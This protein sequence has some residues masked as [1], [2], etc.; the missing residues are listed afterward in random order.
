M[1]AR[2]RV[3][4]GA[5]NLHD[6]QTKP[7]ETDADVEGA[8]CRRCAE[9]GFESGRRATGAIFLEDEMLWAA[10]KPHDAGARAFCRGLDQA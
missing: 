5:E 9:D 3:E 6:R 1:P 10:R 7:L 8:Q 4:T 2:A